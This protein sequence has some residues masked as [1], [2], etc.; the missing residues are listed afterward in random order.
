MFPTVTRWLGAIAPRPRAEMMVGATIALGKAPT[1]E[2][3]NCRRVVREGLG[4]YSLLQF[5]NRASRCYHKTT[6]LV[7]QFMKQI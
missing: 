3:K 1:E 6:C 7:K 5:W 4:M 2:L